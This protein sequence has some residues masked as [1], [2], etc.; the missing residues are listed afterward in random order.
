MI[1][2][3][4]NIIKKETVENIN[5]IVSSEIFPWTLFNESYSETKHLGTG[6]EEKLNKKYK[7][8][9]TFQLVH[10]LYKVNTRQ[11]SVYFNEF[12]NL[13]QEIVNKMIKKDVELLRMKVNLLFKKQN[14]TINNFHIDD[15][16]DL[17]FKT[18]IYY[19]N[20][21]DG[22]TVIYNNNK[23][24]KIKPEAGKVLLFDGDLYHASSNP[25]KNNLR[26]VVNINFRY[27]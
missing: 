1:I 8:T 23:L 22:D 12:Y 16:K 24:K 3:K 7:S 9:D 13:F 15:N 19:I 5:N 20:N 18:A 27:V 10:V 4:T 21:S 6:F 26:K 11:K 2:Q 17:N 14:K 25:I